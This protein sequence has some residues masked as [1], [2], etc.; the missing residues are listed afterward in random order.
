MGSRP[1]TSVSD[2]Q[3][4]E[5]EWRGPDRQN[6]GWCRHEVIL[7]R[8]A[9]SFLRS[10]WGPILGPRFG[11]LI[12]FILGTH[13]EGPKT[14]PNF[15]PKA[16]PFFAQKTRPLLHKKRPLFGK[17]GLSGQL[18]LAK[19]AIRSAVQGTLLAAEFP[20]HGEAGA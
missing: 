19:L 17:F 16:V 2:Q 8:F 5:Q 14:G 12:K 7:A 4:T 15:G 6:T 3:A 9:V 1:C 18:A 10:F 13:F 11:L 20:C